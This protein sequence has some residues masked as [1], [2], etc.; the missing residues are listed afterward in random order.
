MLKILFILSFTISLIKNQNNFLDNN[1]RSSELKEKINISNYNYPNK[2][3]LKSDEF[4]LTILGTND[5]HGQAYGRDISL[6]NTSYSVGGY[7]LLSGA[8][9]ILREEYKDSFLWFDAGDQFT[10]TVESIYTTGGLMVDFYNAMKVDS[11]AIGNHEWDLEEKQLRKWMTNEKGRYFSHNFFNKTENYSKLSDKNKLYLAANL[12]VKDKSDSKNDLPN[13]LPY[14]IFSFLEGKVK[15]GVI[16]LTTLKTVET[17]RA[18]PSEKFELNQYKETII[19]NSEELREKGAKAILIVSHVGMICDYSDE[20]E[21]EYFKL[22]LKN[23]FT[24]TLGNCRGEIVDLIN[25]LEDG[26][27]DGVIAG[28]IHQTVNKFVKGIPIIQNPGNTFTNLFYMKFKQDVNG[29]FHLLKDDTIIE[30]PIPLCSKIFTNNLRCNSNKEP[31]E[32]LEISEFTF[33]NKTFQT[34]P[35]VENVFEKYKDIDETIKAMKKNVI[36]ETEVKL[37]NSWNSET[38]LENFLSDIYKELTKS[39][40]GMLSPGN[41]RN[42]WEKGPISEYEFRNMFPFGGN[43]GRYNVTGG[44]LKKIIITLQES[45]NILYSFSG[46]NMTLIKHNETYYKVDQEKLILSD[47]RKINDT[48]MYSFSSA[49]FM[50]LGGDDMRKFVENGK[51]TINSTEI[52]NSFPI[53]EYF[54]D[55]MKN[56]GNFT[57]EKALSYLGKIKIVE[58]YS[59]NLEFLN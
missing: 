3:N 1:K 5:I 15:I 46:V 23:K 53:T 29:N 44:N 34:D 31:I 7:K 37:N 49:E 6:K 27:V 2:E 32:N 57:E 28:H 16:G 58:N 59:S 22:S 41:V 10:G 21:D 36:M 18:F 52:E 48:E 40:I 42:V 39:D 13:K 14:K 20:L 56:I 45:N 38:I 8:I 54:M 47:G 43:F 4:L 30:G 24:K 11:V 26:I 35:L 25:S 9:N 19:K 12:N 51:M 17:T 55:Y 50:L 33:H